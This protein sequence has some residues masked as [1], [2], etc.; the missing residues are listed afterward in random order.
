MHLPKL[1]FASELRSGKTALADISAVAMR[2]F[3]QNKPSIRS[4]TRRRFVDVTLNQRALTLYHERYASWTAA[5]EGFCAR[6][7]ILYERV[8]SSQPL[9]RLLFHNF[10]KK[11]LVA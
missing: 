10:R 5:I 9:D 6:H 11:G 2:A 3:S 4:S 8:E 7:G 1:S